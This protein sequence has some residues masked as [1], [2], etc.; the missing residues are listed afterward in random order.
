MGRELQ[1][2]CPASFFFFLLLFIPQVQSLAPLFLLSSP[3]FST[4]SSLTSIFHSNFHLSFLP[5]SFTYC[6]R[7]PTII[8]FLHLSS[9]LVLQTY[10]IKT[11]TQQAGLL[12]SGRILLAKRF[13]A[14]LQFRHT[15]K[16]LPPSH[17]CHTCWYAAIS[18][19]A[20]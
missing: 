4:G 12:W 16:L 9:H 19:G 6:R 15:Q 14:L 11:K 5:P 2:I 7:L 10:S 3:L 13:H 17:Q 20:E 18:T 1:V 8:I